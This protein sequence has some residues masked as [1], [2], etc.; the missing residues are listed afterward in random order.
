LD[1]KRVEEKEPAA[2]ATSLLYIKFQSFYKNCILYAFFPQE[3]LLMSPG[4]LQW[5]MN[6]GIEY[7]S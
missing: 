2:A 5:Q 4:A 1:R 3:F 7:A 6:L